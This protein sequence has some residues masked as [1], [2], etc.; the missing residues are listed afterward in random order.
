MKPSILQTEKRCYLCDR[1]TCLERHHV[2]GG[3][4]NRKISEA[5]GIWVWL[6]HDCH[7]GGKNSAQ[8]DKDT[9]IRLKQD[10]QMAFEE[11]HGHDKWMELFM[12]NY[13]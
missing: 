12:K 3:T 4:A 1:K 8:Y 7:T 9:N 13:L 10:A 5:Y 6:C 2:M 11:L